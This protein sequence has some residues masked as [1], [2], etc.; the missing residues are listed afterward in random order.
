MNVPRLFGFSTAIFFACAGAA[1]AQ[2]APSF[3]SNGYVPSAGDWRGAFSAKQ[4]VLNYTPLSLSG[5]TMRGKL[6]VPPATTNGASFSILPGVAPT[7]AING[8]LWL[9][10]SGLFARVNGQN[11]QFLTSASVGTIAGQNADAVVITGGA[12][13]GTPIGATAPSTGSFTS[14]IVGGSSISGVG[15]T[16][17]TVAAGN[18]SRFTAPKIIGGTIDGAP[19]GASNPSSG[20]FTALNVSGSLRGGQATGA[21]DPASYTLAFSPFG[22][23]QIVS[24]PGTTIPLH[25]QMEVTPTGGTAAYEKDAIRGWCETQDPSTTYT[26]DCVGVAGYGWIASGNTKGRAWGLYGEGRIRDNTSDGLVYG[27]ELEVINNGTDQPALDTTTSKYGILLVPGGARP[28]T[29]GIYMTTATGGTFHHGIVASPG[30]LAGASGDAF[31]RLLGKYA[32]YPSGAVTVGYAPANAVAGVTHDVLG[33]SV[34][35]G[36]ASTGPVL[37]SSV[38]TT[39][40]TIES[41]FVTNGY[42]P[43]NFKAGGAT[44]LTI[45]TTN[46]GEPSPTVP[47]TSTSACT[48]GDHAWDAN[49][50]YRCISTNQWKRAALTSW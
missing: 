48:A 36:A 3:F 30:I 12:I 41:G 25:V 31:L 13:N 38:S 49:Y 43:L 33:L 20:G 9:T 22:I 16:A 45:G 24:T 15:T 23:S 19:I 37:L 29:A 5:G 47:A 35:R 7:T 2:S 1:L 14:A 42:V 6:T 18:D 39:A 21:I 8:D 44:R 26:F 11:V 46:V 27:A 10:P 32:V 40:A 4:D 17:G 50:E 34:V 28:A